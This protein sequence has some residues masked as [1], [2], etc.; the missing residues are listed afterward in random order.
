MRIEVTIQGVTPLL[1]NRFTEAN[2]VAVSNGTSSVSVGER[3]LPR[4]QAEVKLYR[5]KDGQ[6]VIPGTNFFASIIEAGKFHKAGKSKVTTQKSSLVPS[7]VSVETFEAALNGAS[8]EVDSRPVV[9]PA[10]KGRIM[11]HRPRFDEWTATFELEVDTEMFSVK[12]VRQLIDDAGKK[13]GL[14]DY[15]PSC[16]GPFG[17]FVVIEWKEAA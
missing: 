10:T 8:W 14:C 17:K 13:I 2:E 7:A 9:I 6:P 3:G 5:D 11:R 15:R 16:K 1:M 4:E 12:F